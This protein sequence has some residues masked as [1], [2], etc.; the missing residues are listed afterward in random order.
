MMLKGNILC[1]DTID[2]PH[3]YPTHWFNRLFNKSVRSERSAQ[4][5]PDKNGKYEATFF[6]LKETPNGQ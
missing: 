4:F 6:D 1:T 2:K 5:I 3:K